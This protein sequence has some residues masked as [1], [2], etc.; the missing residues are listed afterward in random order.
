MEY[1]L[2]FTVFYFYLPFFLNRHEKHLQT[3]EI[4]YSLPSA[5]RFIHTVDYTL[6][7]DIVVR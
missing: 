5:I 3:S 4:I 6:A 1:E 7:Y 2:C